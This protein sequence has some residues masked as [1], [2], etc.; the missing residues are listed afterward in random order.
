[1]EKSLQHK[2][3]NLL[4]QPREYNEY[5]RDTRYDPFRGTSIEGKD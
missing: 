2:L 3:K 1:M 5:N 4:D